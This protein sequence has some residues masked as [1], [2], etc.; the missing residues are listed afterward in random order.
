LALDSTGPFGLGSHTVTLIATDSL[1][2]SS[3]SNATVTVIDDTPPSITNVSASPSSIW[4]PDLKMVNVTVNYTT[5]DNC[6]PASGLTNK[7]SVSSNQGTTADW[8]IV[9]THHVLLRADKGNV[10]TITITSTDSRGNKASMSV[11]INVPH[12]HGK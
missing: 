12:D 3:S 8:Q 1:G 7:L 10:Y 4:P 11:T 2:A 6:A 5:S 9:D